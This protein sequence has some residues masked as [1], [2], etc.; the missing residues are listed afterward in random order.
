MAGVL[1][2]SGLRRKLVGPLTVTVLLRVAR[3]KHTKLDYPK[4]DI[5]N[6]SKSVLD[7]LTGY[8][9][10]DDSQV[11]H[12]KATKSWSHPGESGAFKVLIESAE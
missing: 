4:P 9:W 12:L 8:A 3:P 10:V 2:D 11:I 7:A 1:F 5:D 6:Y